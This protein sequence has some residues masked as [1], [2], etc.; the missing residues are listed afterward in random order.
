[1]TDKSRAAN[2]CTR[3]RPQI[4]FQGNDTHLSGTRQ[5]ANDNGDFARDLAYSKQHEPEDIEALKRLF[6]T[7]YKIEPVAD[8]KRQRAGIDYIVRYTEPRTDAPMTARIDAKRRKA[9]T[10][11]YWQDIATP[12]LTFEIRNNGGKLKS[13]LTDPNEQTGFYMFT[14]DDTGDV[15]LIPFQM[16]RFVLSQPAT[17]ERWRTVANRNGKGAVNVYIPA[18]EFVYCSVLKMAKDEQGQ[19]PARLALQVAYRLVKYAGTRWSG[20]LSAFSWLAERFRN[21]NDNRNGG[22]GGRKYGN[23]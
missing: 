4:T 16:A 5:A 15:Y 11:R 20:V 17:A 8:E 1:M 21:D 14:Y 18:D 2:A 19:F 13:C 22:D 23:S 7:A 10:C 6:P 9:G 3:H 12:E